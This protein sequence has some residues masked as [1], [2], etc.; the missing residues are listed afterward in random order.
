[1]ISSRQL[2]I[3]QSI[4]DDYILTGVPVGSRTLSKRM[5]GSLSSAT[6]RNEMA[7]LEDEGYLEQPHTSAGRMPTEKAYRLYVDTLMRVNKLN[8]EELRT[9][10]KYFSSQMDEIDNVVATA[11]KALSDLTHMT[12]VVIVPELKGLTIK[13]I[14]IVRMSGR[15][16]LMLIVFANGKVKDEMIDIDESMDDE[17]L[18]MLSRVITERVADV[19]LEEAVGAVRSLSDTDMWQHRE[20]LMKL[21]NAVAESRDI[22]KEVVFGGAGNILN[23]PE[24][25]DI[26]KARQFLELL[27]TKDAIYNMFRRAANMEFT[28]RIGNENEF[29]QLKDMSVVTATYRIGDRDMGTF[30]IIGPTRMDYGKVVSLM[31]GISV[32][33]NKIIDNLLAGDK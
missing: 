28:I 8:A 31:K 33:M 14:Q 4:I 9:I 10:R 21:I 17:Y 23:H 27:D 32:S 22:S 2:M 15:R 25:R 24:L 20:F 26:D 30:G 6:I 16:A 1:M 13:R 19:P 5:E 7:D 12:S 29:D 11:A 18:E 3:L